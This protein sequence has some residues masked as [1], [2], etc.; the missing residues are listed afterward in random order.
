MKSKKRGLFMIQFL[1]VLLLWAEVALANKA[2]VS[3]EAPAESTKG[4]EITIRLTI[5]HSVDNRFHHVEWG[6][7]ILNNN[8]IGW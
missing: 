4:S 6:Q 7:P 8:E 5:T 1:M 3:N 2:S